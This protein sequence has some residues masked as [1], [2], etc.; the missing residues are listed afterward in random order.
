[1]YNILFW[2]EEGGG[3]GAYI[4]K[5]VEFLSLFVLKLMFA[6]RRLEAITCTSISHDVTYS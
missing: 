1:M 4:G 3:G 5:A 6:Q 2:W